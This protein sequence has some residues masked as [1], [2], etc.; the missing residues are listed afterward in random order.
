MIHKVDECRTE[1]TLPTGAPFEVLYPAAL[2]STVESEI[3][4]R[5]L[6]HSVSKRQAV[7]QGEARW[8]PGVDELAEFAG[9]LIWHDAGTAAAY[10]TAQ[11]QQ[12]TALPTLYVELLAPTARLL[13]GLRRSGQF[14]RLRVML[15]RYRLL[16][17]M[18]QLRRARSPVLTDP[19]A[20][21]H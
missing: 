19:A 14:G 13:S 12:G 10:V 1:S 5:L 21:P 9:L 16:R 6:M 20:A 17:V 18:R 8:R 11:L 15:A 3:V 2:V 7:R 4:P